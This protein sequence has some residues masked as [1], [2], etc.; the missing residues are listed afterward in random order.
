VK[1]GPLIKGKSLPLLIN[2]PTGLSLGATLDWLEGHRSVLDNLT[3]RAGVIL[4]RDLPIKTPND[5]QSICRAIRPQLR[6]YSGGD[7]PRTSLTEFVYT[8]TEY[9]SGLEVLLHNELSYAGW[10]PDRVFFGCLQPAATGG[11]THVADGREIYRRLDPKIRK[12]FENKGVTY[13]QHLRDRS[14]SGPGKSW[15]ETFESTRREQAENYLKTSKMGFEWTADGIKTHAFHQAILKH[16]VTKEK[17]WHNQADQWHRL[18]PSVKDSV[19]E[20]ITKPQ[21]TPNATAFSNHVVFGDGSE[22]NPND[23]LRIRAVSR[24]CEVLF[25]WKEGDVM[26]I[27]NVMAMHGRKPFTGLRQTVVAMA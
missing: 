12:D 19:G 26:I 20:E 2:Q 23:L 13:I 25:A 6:K 14:V 24:S 7:S 8:S 22:I 5:F 16:S 11:E 4:L 3:H 15:Q 21:S 27:D 18:L 9:Q 10:S 17:C 1:A